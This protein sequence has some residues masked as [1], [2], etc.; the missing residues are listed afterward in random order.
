M[1]NSAGSTAPVSEDCNHLYMIFM[2]NDNMMML[3][4]IQSQ[5]GVLTSPGKLTVVLLVVLQPDRW[6][7]DSHKDDLDA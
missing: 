6:L 5:L 4:Q 7:P 1:P 2:V 3:D